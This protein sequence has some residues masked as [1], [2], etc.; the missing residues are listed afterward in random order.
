[1]SKTD[2]I[3]LH[4]LDDSSGIAVGYWDRTSQD[5]EDAF[6][7][8]RHDH[9]TCM[10]LESGE[11]EVLLDF[12]HFT[13]PARTLFIS[14]PGQVHQVLHS[15]DASGW[16]LSFENHLIEESLR[17][18]LDQCLAEIISVELSGEEYEWF[19]IVIS[20]LI[21]LSS[22]NNGSFKEVQQPLL[23][24]F[25]AQA[26]ISYRI[27]SDI[28]T[29]NFASRPIT[30]TKQFR[31]LVKYNFRTLK[32]PSEFAEKLHITVSHL[33]DTVKKVTGQSASALIH[34]EIVREAQRML[35]YTDK[36]VKEIAYDLGYLD[37]KYFIRLFTK[38][39]GCSPTDYRK[40]PDPP[41]V[42][43]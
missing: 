10:L 4:K 2:S 37:S 42:S 15:I 25:I 21:K 11:L 28:G 12:E 38:K 32:R 19:T 36:S 40:Q 22:L 7:P 17:V 34:H 8:H 41:A 33:N 26:G 27:N 9:Y 18:G 1:M 30:I 43:T 39:I 14:P 20:S 5:M 29:S 35:Y 13:M 3:I 16:Y 23:S 6:L 31:N 24:A